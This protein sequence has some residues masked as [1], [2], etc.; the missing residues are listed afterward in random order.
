MFLAGN[1]LSLYLFWL[2][3]GGDIQSPVKYQRE[4]SRGIHRNR[5]KDRI[6]LLL[7]ILIDKPAFLF[8]KLLMLGD[9]VKSLIPEGRQYRPVVG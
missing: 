9:E 4:G 1:A 5:C 7:K 6:Y 8:S 2:N 3:Q